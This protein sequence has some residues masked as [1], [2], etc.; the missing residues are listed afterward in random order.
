MAKMSS[1]TSHEMLNSRLIQSLPGDSFHQM[2]AEKLNLAH[3]LHRSPLDK[4]RSG[5]IERAAQF[6]ITSDV[7][8]N[9]FDANQSFP[10]ATM[11]MHKDQ[12][13][14]LSR[15]DSIGGAGI[16]DV[17]FNRPIS[18]GSFTKSPMPAADVLNKMNQSLD[19]SL[20]QS[21]LF[22]KYTST[23]TSSTPSGYNADSKT[24][25]YA[26]NPNKAVVTIHP[27]TTEIL[28]ANDM[29]CEL[30][31]YADEDLLNEKLSKLVRVKRKEQESLEELDIDP[32]TGN[33]LKISGRIMEA[34]H[35]DGTSLSVSVWTNMV[36]SKDSSK[37]VVV[38]EPVQKIA[39]I[40]TVSTQDLLLTCDQSFVSLFG[41]RSS[42][43]LIGENIN[44]VIPSINL[45]TSAKN[46]AQEHKKQATTG[47]S[48]LGNSFPVSLHVNLTSEDQDLISETGEA[49]II[50]VWVFTSISGLVT[51]SSTG[52]IKAVNDHF[53]KFFCGYLSSEVIGKHISTLIPDLTYENG[54]GDDLLDSGSIPLPPFDEEPESLEIQGSQAEATESLAHITIQPSN[55]IDRTS[56]AELLKPLVEVDIDVS[57]VKLK[58]NLEELQCEACRLQ[59]QNVNQL[60]PGEILECSHSPTVLDVE[61]DTSPK[62]S[63]QNMT[64]T[65]SRSV[66]WQTKHTLKSDFNLQNGCYCG[67]IQHKDGSLLGVVIQVKRLELAE[68]DV[69][70]CL[71]ISQDPE[72][73]GETAQKLLDLTLSS[74]LNHSLQTPHSPQQNGDGNLDD[75]IEFPP[76]DG[77]YRKSYKTTLSVG[78][79]AFGFVK[80]AQRRT[81]NKEFVV[82]FIKKSKVLKE[83]WIDNEK[84][85]HISLEIH[86]LSKL[87]HPNIVKL[88]DVFENKEYF[89]LVMEK[90]GSGIDMFEFIEKNPHMDERLASY[91]FR[92]V[93][94]AVDYLRSLSILHRDIKDENIILN[95]SFDIKL[96]E[97]LIEIE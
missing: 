44:K 73:L 26:S 90:H 10:K 52:D 57:N 13:P 45:P 12:S 83:C 69:V 93:V 15:L 68:G 66:S 5:K 21:W 95:E 3:A 39:A 65:P 42:S 47:L 88:I 16:Q 75:T 18:R 58:S 27:K 35:S 24:S 56:T 71:W 43:E 9:S 55:V 7:C 48:K 34:Q 77:L 79:G 38:M 8:S 2:K 11:T 40:A 36:G 41:Y 61:N 29:A 6:G 74:T 92:Q 46:L 20:S 1:M 82:K 37:C 23:P 64:S 33:I 87:D 91:L 89:Q 78:K 50:T 4:I 22:S 14:V 17:S 81:D 72:Y 60:E 32:A 25:Y 80:L 97:F 59:Q 19:Q 30:F 70:N 96:I 94:E 84:L 76:A 67:H 62:K 49:Y 31:G 28:M 51:V 63:G 86:L 54:V 53:S 85:G